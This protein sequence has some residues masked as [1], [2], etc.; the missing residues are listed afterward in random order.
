MVRR[1]NR[2]HLCI[3]VAIATLPFTAKSQALDPPTLWSV[4]ALSDS[5]IE[6]RWRNNDSRT[7]GYL[8]YRRQQGVQQFSFLGLITGRECDTNHN[9]K[10]STTY[11]YAL[12]AVAGSDTSDFSNSDSATTMPPIMKRPLVTGLDWDY[13]MRRIIVAYYDSS[14]REDSIRVYVSKDDLPFNSLDMTLLR[15]TTVGTDTLYIPVTNLNCWYCVYLVAYFGFDT[16]ASKI[17]RT[18]YCLD[19]DSLIASAPRIYLG[20]KIGA[21]PIS[22]K[23]WAV[24]NGNMVAVLESNSP[25]QTYSII[26]ITDPAH[27][28]FKEYRSTSLDFT[29]AS[30]LTWSIPPT[31]K[32]AGKGNIIR[33]VSNGGYDNDNIYRYEI[34]S[35]GDITGRRLSSYPRGNLNAFPIGFSPLSDS[36][37]LVLDQ[38]NGSPGL[39]YF[40]VVIPS[41]S[42][43]PRDPLKYVFLTQTNLGFINGF[44]YIGRIMFARYEYDTLSQRQI[45]EVHIWDFHDTGN[46]KSCFICKKSIISNANNFDSVRHVDDYLL[47]DS[48]IPRYY[49]AFFD[50]QKKQVIFVHDSSLAIYSADTAPIAGIINPPSKPIQSQAPALHFRN[51]TIIAKINSNHTGPVTLQLRDIAGRLVFIKTQST[52]SD[53]TVRY[54]IGAI[55]N[56]MYLVS[57]RSSEFTMRRSV[58]VYR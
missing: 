24:K 17:S 35:A 20:E 2:L 42:A 36:C 10:A 55:A 50:L 44:N 37:M 56:G 19:A 51:G 31:K 30:L 54:K 4:K 27:P 11:I 41:G 7:Q 49:E 57:L 47:I 28:R 3:T 8:L 33:M 38:L 6:E 12:R 46:V 1:R 53:G 25:A 13:E 45:D 9:L 26:D 21:T 58:V 14:N 23:G 34:D 16:L 22:Y 18:I 40:S 52:N 29:D 39:I 15:Q 32:Y 5:S 48:T 43:V